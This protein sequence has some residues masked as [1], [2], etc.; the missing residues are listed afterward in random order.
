MLI[1]MP[2]AS[3]ARRNEIVQRFKKLPV[4]IQML[5]GL[6]ELA[7]GRVSVADVREVEI[8]DLLGR[9]PLKVNHERIKQSVAGKVVMVTGAGGSIGSELCRQLL[10]ASPS[11]LL[12]L[13]QA[14]HNL[15]TIHNDLEQRRSRLGSK[16]RVLPLLCDV[17]D[18]VRI[19]EIFSVFNPEVIYHAAAYKHVPMVE[20]NPSE[21]LRNNV[22]GTRCV[23][24]AA[25]RQ[26][27]SSFV[28]VSTDKAVR[29]TNI[30]GASK[31]LCEMILQAFA[32]Q[33]GHSTC[34]SMVRF[35]NVLGSSGSVVPLFRRQIKEGGPLSITHSEITRY[36][37]SIPEASQ[38]V[39]KAGTFASGGEVF[40]L[41]MGEPVKIIDLARRMVELSGL[42]VRNEAHPDG[43][44]EIKV[45]GLR[46]GEKLYEELLI[47]NNP[48]ATLNPRI[49]KASEQFIPWDELEP[50]LACLKDAIGRNDVGEIKMLLK[51]IIPEYQPSTET[52]D[53]VS[54]EKDLD[55]LHHVSVLEPVGVHG[56]KEVHYRPPKPGVQIRKEKESL[57]AIARPV[58][59]GIG[60]ESH[61]SESN[62]SEFGDNP[63]VPDQTILIVEDENVTSLILKTSLNGSNISTL[64]AGSG[65]DAVELV[66][67]HPEVSLVLMDIML[68]EMDGFEA[69]RL[70]K[71]LRPE[72]PVIVQTSSTLQ[73]EKDNADDAGCDSLISKPIDKKELYELI[74][75]LF[76]A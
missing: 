5:P 32:A 24:E 64:H 28:L 58:F 71:E 13:E 11:V 67:R 42:T 55:V 69:T 65:L 21:G 25:I 43:D 36:F 63:V 35:G 66:K 27:V 33:S 26:G 22:F 50:E 56:K 47:G 8:E 19:A 16:T 57:S 9:D 34:F 60:S 74:Q 7:D 59:A 23:A 76:S 4:R 53:L 68:K 3:R 18:T 2:S 6:E 62:R 37:M 39:I 44:I 1:A 14:E 29:P 15:Y 54:M 75:H 51:R 49:F 45:T 17:T 20:H 10:A 46:P 73:I 38:L 70:I 12:L 52:S 72:L 30:M 48:E 61:R 41:D 40:L 31:R